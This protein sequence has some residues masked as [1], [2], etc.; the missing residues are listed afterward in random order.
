VSGATSAIVVWLFKLWTMPLTVPFAYQRDALAQIVEVKSVLDHGWYQSNP[1]LGFPVGLDHRDFTL[2]SDNLHY[3]LIKFL[4]IFSH[5]AVLVTNLYFLLSFVLVALSAFFVVRYFGVSRPLSFVAALLFTFLPYHFLRGTAQLSL[6]AYFSVP[7][8]CLLTIVV[9]ENSPPFFRA[10]NGRARFVWKGR[11]ELWMV[12]AAIVIASSGVYYAAFCVV[13]MASVGV[14]RLA[15]T[16]TWRALFSAGL[17]CGVIGAA[18]IANNLPSLLYWAQ[19]HR[20]PTVAVRS[21]AESD[22]YSL[23]PIQML[24]PIFGHRVGALADLTTEVFKAPNNSEA[25]QFLGLIGSLGFLALL[26]VFLGLGAMRPSDRSPPLLLRLASLTVLAV[27]FGVS[28]GLEWVAGLVGF[29]EIRSWNRISVFIAFYALLA[30]GLFGDRLVARLPS[31]DA[32]RWVVA[33]GA[34]VLVA[35]GV[36][37]QTSKAI[38]PDSRNFEAQWNS[39][40]R[41]VDRIDATMGNGDAVFE[42]PYIPWPEAELEVPGAY[43]MADYDP[44]RGYLHSDDLKWSYGGMRG[45]ASDWQGQVHQHPV[46]TMLR[47]IAAVGYRG[48][49]VDRFGYPNRAKQIESRLRAVIGRRPIVGA[50]GRFAFYD[51]RPYAKQVRSELGPAGVRA[52]RTKTL[53]DV[54]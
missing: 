19:H 30:V 11:R 43:G 31:F 1:Q 6:A 12:L 24:S 8:A 32:K 28:G 36:L 41:F 25:T 53:R 44:F 37:D 9:W 54:S 23:R 22:F 10:D 26:V 35:V 14:L 15:T 33:G 34:V 49:W 46:A 17:L 5:N 40:Q 48:V 7:I 38:V 29:T 39:E 13:L 45:R 21:V 2:G 3:L 50:H 4:G 27:L 52:L 47:D 51:L 42:L 20:N 18:T 16:R